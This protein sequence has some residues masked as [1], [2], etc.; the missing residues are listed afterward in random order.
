VRDA[1]GRVIATR[2]YQNDKWYYTH[3]QVWNDRG[4]KIR[5]Y[6]EAPAD[7]TG[8]NSFYA[9]N[10][11]S[12]DELG[13]F[14]EQVDPRCEGC[15]HFSLGTR[16]QFWYNAQRRL[17]ATLRY[18]DLIVPVELDSLYY[19]SAGNITRQV[20]YSLRRGM[21]QLRSLNVKAFDGHKRLV[22]DNDLWLSEVRELSRYD[23]ENRYTPRIGPE[24]PNIY[25]QRII[26]IRYRP[27]GQRQQETEY[28]ATGL[29][30]LA[31]ETNRAVHYPPDSLCR[32]ADDALTPPYRVLEIKKERTTYRYNQRGYLAQC[33]E[34][35]NARPDTVF[36][37]R[38]VQS[39]TRW[40]HQ[41]Y[42]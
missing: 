33:T 41:Y 37:S 6:G 16:Y 15:D 36:L 20:S 25:G 22:A 39:I 35:K 42:D 10:F 34:A 26:R 7:S 40:Q 29:L 38:D 1:L 30:Y 3:H 23:G 24:L 14:T 28:T 5:E 19:D 21:T 2:F 17:V 31:A 32:R 11:Y 13:N 27:D 9:L 18:D 12:Y 4:Q 8:P